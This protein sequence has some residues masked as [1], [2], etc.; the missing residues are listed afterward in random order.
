MKLAG[1]AI[2]L[3][4]LALS[5]CVEDGYAGLSLGPVMYDGYYDNYYGPIYDGYWGGDGYFYY[6]R[7]EQDR[8]YLRGDRNH[9]RRPGGNPGRNF[10]PFQ[11][12]TQP[13]QGTRTPHYPREGGR[14]DRH[15]QGHNNP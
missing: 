6:R 12:Q 4:S 15:G 7:N 5:A 1:L 2:A 14:G 8:R 11:G 13:Q 10:H 3:S 9:F